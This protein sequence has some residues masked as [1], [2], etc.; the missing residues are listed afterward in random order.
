MT[1]PVWES[2]ASLLGS[3]LKVAFIGQKEEYQ[4]SSWSTQQIG[5]HKTVPE[6]RWGESLSNVLSHTALSQSGDTCNTPVLGR[7]FEA[8][9]ILPSQILW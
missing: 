8:A 4:D 5:L 1:S 7:V 9:W 2:F 3:E 6:G